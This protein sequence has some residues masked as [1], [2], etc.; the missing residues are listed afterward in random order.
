MLLIN[1]ALA[2]IFMNYERIKAGAHKLCLMPEHFT[3]SPLLL[4]ITAA[5]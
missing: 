4:S 2:V 3:M 1:L 5:S